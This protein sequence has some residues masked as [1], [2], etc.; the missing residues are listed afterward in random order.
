MTVSWSAVSGAKGYEI[1]YATNAKF[2]KAVKKAQTGRS[3]SITKLGKGKTYY[4]R[5]RAYKT[6]STGAKIYGRYS[7]TMK[8][9]IAK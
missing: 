2:T 1:S 3:L 5:V 6:D 9:R 7:K 4:V 8:I